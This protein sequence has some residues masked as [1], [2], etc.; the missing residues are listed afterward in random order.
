MIIPSSIR[1]STTTSS[2]AGWIG[3]DSTEPGRIAGDA[4][5]ARLM[6]ELVVASAC[7]GCDKCIEAC[8]T[9]V[10]DREVDGIPEIARQ[11]DCQ[12]CF[13]CEA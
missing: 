1:T 12:T 8:P 3:L 13:M 9:D 11:R 5:G 10:F 4:D 7:I 6:I 2:P